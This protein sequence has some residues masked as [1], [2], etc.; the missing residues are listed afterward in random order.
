MAAVC[1]HLFN[2]YIAGRGIFRGGKSGDH[3]RST[4]SCIFRGFLFRCVCR[5]FAVRTTKHVQNT[6]QCA[7]LQ[8]YPFVIC[9]DRKTRG[10]KFRNL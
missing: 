4:K 9:L 5:F 2:I 6:Y 3:N 7:W 1:L 10:H 8:F